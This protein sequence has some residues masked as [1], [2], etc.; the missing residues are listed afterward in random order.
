MNKKL[1]CLRSVPFLGLTLPGSAVL[2]AD[3]TERF[4]ISGF[5]S[6]RYSMTDEKAYFHGNRETGINDA[7]SFQGT[8]LGL[9]M[10]AADENDYSTHVD[11]AK[12]VFAGKGTPPKTLKSDTE[13][14]SWVASTP[15]AVGYVNSAAADDSVKVLMVSK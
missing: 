11:W 5:Y 6:A 7:G 10:S 1:A 3:W 15:G 12:I 13:V 4:N 14:I 8:K 9:M 2:A